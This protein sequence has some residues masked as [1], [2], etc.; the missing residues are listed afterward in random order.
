MS[1]APH[2][3]E[4][5]TALKSQS[6]WILALLSFVTLFIYTGHYIVKQTQKLNQFLDDDKKIPVVFAWGQLV[7]VYAGILAAILY[8]FVLAPSLPEVDTATLDFSVNIFSLILNII[9]IVWAFMARRRV[10][11]LLGSSKGEKQWFHVFWTF[12]FSPLYINYKIN[13]I[14]KAEVL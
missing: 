9:W 11:I 6:T 3:K 10:H 5:V 13:K 12:L 1:L 4:I 7:F 2:Q 14:S 8:G